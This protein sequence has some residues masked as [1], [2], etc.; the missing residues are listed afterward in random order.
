VDKL[1]DLSRLQGGA[2]SPR[3]VQCSVDEIVD[4]ALEQLPSPS[5]QF[6]LAIDPELP[7]VLVDAAQVER[8]LVNLFENAS[9]F[10]GDKPVKV[11]ATASGSDVIL[12][13]S[14]CGPGIPEEEREQ[15][16]EP[17][18]RGSDGHGNHPG[19]GLGLAIVRGF[20]EAN[21]GRVWAECPGEGTTFV[22]RLP[23]QPMGTSEAEP[24]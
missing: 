17:F 2:A 11:S 8:A 13:I 21:G 5:D 9:R 20:V 7:S 22:V 6:E 1:L 4:I 14:D 10:S 3:R 18:Y 23:A 16:F 19:S 24:R 12:R 15:V